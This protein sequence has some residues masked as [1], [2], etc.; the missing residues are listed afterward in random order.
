MDLS[1]KF[2]SRALPWLAGILAVEAVA[3]LVYLFNH[4]DIYFHT[5]MQALIHVPQLTLLLGFAGAVIWMTSGGAS[6][7]PCQRLLYGAAASIASTALARFVDVDVSTDSPRGWLFLQALV[8]ILTALALP[9][10]WGCAFAREE[11]LSST[12]ITAAARISAGVTFASVVLLV[13][14]E[15]S[16]MAALGV[17]EIVHRASAI[18]A[19]SSFVM[20]S[21]RGCLLWGAW[22]TW[23]PAADEIALRE[24]AKRIH[25]M[26]LGALGGSFWSAV[27]SAFNWDAESHGFGSVW[28]RNVP[29]LIWQG[30]AQLTLTLMATLL[31]AVALEAP[32]R[33]SETK[34]QAPDFQPP[35]EPPRDTSPI[36]VP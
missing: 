23:R 34:P 4:F 3:A 32:E 21:G 16:A 15:I 7:I 31:V 29:I 18:G 1:P 35:P 19:L 17:V 12:R 13:A 6:R 5:C 20:V 36:D 30:L 14:A 24:R 22:D 28:Q 33:L 11:D 10:L 26:M 27:I 8:A 2:L 9:G 25:T